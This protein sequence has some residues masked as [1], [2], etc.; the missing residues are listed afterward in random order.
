MPHLTRLGVTKGFLLFENQS[1][2]S[3]EIWL[4]RSSEA[5]N[6]EITVTGSKLD[7]YK[8]NIHPWEKVVFL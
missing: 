6:S 3:N 2:S 1:L 8:K 5:L 4:A 7:P